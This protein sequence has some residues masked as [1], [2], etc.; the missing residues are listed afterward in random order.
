MSKYASEGVLVC[1]FAGVL[2]CWFELGRL[3][4]CKLIDIVFPHL[5]ARRRRDDNF[6]WSFGQKTGGEITP[7]NNNIIG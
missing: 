1:K 4:V 7:E 6:I 3:E 2:V 5:Q